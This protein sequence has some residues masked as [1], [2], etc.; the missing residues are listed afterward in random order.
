[1]IFVLLDKGMEYS[2]ADG[3]EVI[4]Q[5]GN[6]LPLQDIVKAVCQHHDKKQKKVERD[7]L[8]IFFRKKTPPNISAFFLKYKPNSTDQKKFSIVESKQQISTFYGQNWSQI[9]YFPPERQ[10][11]IAA[12]R[13]EDQANRRHGGDSPKAT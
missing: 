7:G 2:I 10:K 9:L 12:K 13:R 8:T 1:M 3:K 5:D 11:E 6:I 4:L